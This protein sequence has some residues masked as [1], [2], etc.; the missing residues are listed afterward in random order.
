MGSDSEDSSSADGD[1]VFLQVF[2]TADSQMFVPMEA[3]NVLVGRVVREAV[4]R[5]ADRFPA[6]DVTIEPSGT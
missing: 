6:I 5:F 2:V 4:D 3:K 1:E